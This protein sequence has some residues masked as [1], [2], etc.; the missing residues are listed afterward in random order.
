MNAAHNARNA[1]RANSQTTKK[2]PECLEY[3]PIH[4]QV[5]PSCKTPVGK[6]DRHGMASRK[7][8]W[9]GYATA[10]AAWIVFFLYVW[11]AFLRE[12]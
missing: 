6:I 12:N 4:A 2:C 5:C 10:A 9:K 7:T 8:D 3:M 1:G 11:W